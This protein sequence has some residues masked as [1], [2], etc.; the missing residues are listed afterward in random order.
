MNSISD[1]PKELKRLAAK[2][3]KRQPAEFGK[4]VKGYKVRVSH[5]VLGPDL[6]SMVTACLLCNGET[7]EVTS[8]QAKI[9]S[10]SIAIQKD[11]VKLIGDELVETTGLAV[12]PKW[13]HGR[14]CFNCHDDLFELARTV[15]HVN[16]AGEATYKAYVKLEAV[17]D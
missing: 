6:P 13:K 7:S 14:V 16:K 12:F 2:W 9:M 15:H 10:G 4:V 5:K 1:D 17:D 8:I 11:S 3:G